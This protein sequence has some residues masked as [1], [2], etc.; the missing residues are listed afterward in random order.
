MTHP[1][2]MPSIFARMSNHAY[3][4]ARFEAHGFNAYPHG[5]N[6][7]NDGTMA[8]TRWSAGFAKAEQHTNQTL[9]R[10]AS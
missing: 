3:W 6:P 1:C 5:L 2:P 8:A 9:Q 4:A 7:Y 10:S